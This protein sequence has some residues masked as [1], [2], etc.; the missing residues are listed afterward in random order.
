MHLKTILFWKL[1]FLEEFKNCQST[2][3]RVFECFVIICRR[4]ILL[5]SGQIL[6]T[7]WTLHLNPYNLYIPIVIQIG[8][9]LTYRY[10]IIE[11]FHSQESKLHLTTHLHS[12]TSSSFSYELS[13]ACRW[14]REK[15]LEGDRAINA[16][17]LQDCHIYLEFISFHF[18]MF[19][20]LHH[21]KGL[22]I[23]SVIR[24]QTA[25]I[26]FHSK[27]FWRCFLSISP[28]HMILHLK[29]TFSC[30]LNAYALSLLINIYGY[31]SNI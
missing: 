5:S 18:R 17:F 26:V 10:V 22:V 16:D 6:H 13:S 24:Q 4:I 8:K 11:N 25:H 29:R 30:S 3:Y 12:N 28:K 27:F 7:F 21:I 2:N 14:A 15:D 9:P 23:S 1:L 31:Q 20:F 19:L